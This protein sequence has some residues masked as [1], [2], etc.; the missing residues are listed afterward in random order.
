ME[1]RSRKSVGWPIVVRLERRVSGAIDGKVKGMMDRGR[2]RKK[3]TLRA[4]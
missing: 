4:L 2:R 3:K 1:L